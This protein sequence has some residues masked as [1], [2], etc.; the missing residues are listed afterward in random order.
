MS[1]DV[2]EPTT[3]QHILTLLREVETEVMTGAVFDTTFM[4]QHTEF[5]SLEQLLEESPWTIQS[6][7]DF[8]TIPD[9]ELDEFITTH[10]DFSDWGAMVESAVNRYIANNVD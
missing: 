6:A 8:E 9:E 7:A 3:L 5:E 1:Y 2:S 10:S 4:R